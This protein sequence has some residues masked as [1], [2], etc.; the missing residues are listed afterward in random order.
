MS[1][2][3]WLG[4]RWKLI[5]NIVTL[6]ALGILVWALRDQLSDTLSNLAR[7]NAWLLLLLIPVEALN[8]HAQAK[9]YQGL[10]KMVGN[11][12]SYK[13]LFKTSLELNF[14][15]HVFPSG[16]A[17]GISYFTLR[18]RDGEKLTGSKATLIHIVKL[19]LTF[20]SFE[21]LIVFGLFSLSL[22]GNVN[23]LTIMVAA[24]L[25]TLLL[26]GTAL[27][28]YIVGSKQRIN[29]FFTAV[30]KGLNRIIQLVRPGRPETINISNARQ[31][32][33]DFHANY[34]EIKNNWRQLRGPFWYA[35]LANITEVAALYVVYMAFDQYV[36]IGAVI[37]AYAVANFAGLVS[38]LPGGIGI[39]EALMTAV[40]ASA[41]VSAAV[42]LPVT[43]MYRVLNTAIQVPPGYYLYHKALQRGGPLVRDSRGS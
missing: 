36:N 26:V 27:F 17:A 31:V 10:F 3:S 21:L 35:L 15:N 8:Y 30:T 43:I 42:S 5:L 7:V 14:V 6:M 34:A 2:N 32:F 33:D 12:L 11:K 24:S 4:R 38:V 19:G 25:S 13:S 16:G 23:N 9:L 41:G 40:L 39:Y 20:L 22:M 18:L 1:K 37:I 29:N 28:A